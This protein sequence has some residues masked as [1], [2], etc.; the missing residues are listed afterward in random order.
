[1]AAEP[2][3]EP[4]TDPDNLHVTDAKAGKVKP[5]NLHVTDVKDGEMS[6]D[7]LHVTD[8]PA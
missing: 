7:N 3:T 5:N 2:T 4:I 8:K 1:M 6:T